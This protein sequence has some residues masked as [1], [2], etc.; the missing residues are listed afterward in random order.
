MSIK[1]LV[2]R[3]II[4]SKEEDSLLRRRLESHPAAIQSLTTVAGA[5][6]L[7][8]TCNLL[9]PR[10]NQALRRLNHNER[11]TCIPVSR[12][13]PM[14]SRLSI[15][16]FFVIILYVSGSS[17]AFLY[18]SNKSISLL[19]VSDD[20]KY[21]NGF[22]PPNGIAQVT[23]YFESGTRL[24]G[25]FEVADGESITFFICND[26]SYVAVNDNPYASIDRHEHLENVRNGSFDF[27]VPYDNYW[28]LILINLDTEAKWVDWDT[29]IHYPSDE[30]STDGVPLQPLIT[31]LIIAGIILIVF[32][33]A[34]Y[35]ITNSISLPS[36]LGVL[37][38]EEWNQIVDAIQEILEV[39][40]TPLWSVHLK[41]RLHE[42]ISDSIKLLFTHYDDL[43]ALLVKEG[44]LKE[45]DDNCYELDGQFVNMSEAFL[46][47][48]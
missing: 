45:T 38:V 47:K 3:N 40:K 6:G 5:R 48:L 22:V 29:W 23:D 35:A 34:K 12:C 30:S 14:T 28:H 43:L 42:R 2:S 39:E 16:I 27:V 32:V 19:Q 21:W 10:G 17:S 37:T 7:H 46:S 31:I 33:C 13:L 24:Y 41:N 36:V 4:Q 44:L 20:Y 8:I 15:Y 26:T 9:T 1:S 18:D 25:N 11:I